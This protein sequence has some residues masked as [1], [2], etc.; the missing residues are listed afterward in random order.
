MS[1][2]KFEAPRHGSLGFLPR[3]RTS[4][5]HGKIKAFP[6]DSKKK[7]P[8]FTAFAGYKAG[9]THVVRDLDKVGSKMHK[10]EVVESV[11]IIETPPIIVIGLVGYAETPK[12]LRTIGTV[13]AQHLSEEARRRFYKQWHKSK[14][15]KAFT[16]NAKKYTTAKRNI[17]DQVWKIK[18]GA[19]VVRAIVHTQVSKLPFGQR[20]AHILEIQVNGGKNAGAKVDF[21]LS[22]F[23]KPIPVSGVFAENEQIDVAG[24]TKGK[25]FK[26]VVSRWG[27]KKLPRK[28]HKG[29]RKVACI[30]A[31][32]PSRVSWAVP[33]AGQKGFHS[34]TEVNKKVYRIGKAIKTESGKVVHNNA[35]TEFDLIAKSITPMGGFPRYG[36]VNED[37]LMLKGSVM[38]P[39]CRLVL[40]RKTLRPQ[41]SRTALEQ[42]SLKFIDTSSKRGHGRFQTSDEKSKFLGPLKPKRTA[43]VRT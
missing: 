40:L 37:F 41:T 21:I 26:G 23:E 3:K 2:R 35:S 42:I 17:D 43:P 33:R 18:R 14:G 36:P 28:T 12:G 27:V 7:P 1:H 9:M 4:H 19:K 5:I 34:R 31:W 8:H 25:G 30:G 6:K 29:L 24:V 39:H 11:T 38:G 20:K 16:R 10:K 15:K 13:W 22:H 32:H